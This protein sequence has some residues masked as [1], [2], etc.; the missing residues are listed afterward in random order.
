MR[1]IEYLE[2]LEE[3]D[4]ECDQEECVEDYQIVKAKGKKKISKQNEKSEYSR[5][6]Q[7]RRSPELASKI[8]RK[9]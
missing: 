1:Q 4:S 2:M 3:S 8:D 6:T 5:E 7:V 9:S